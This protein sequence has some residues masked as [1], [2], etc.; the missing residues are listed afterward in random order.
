[1]SVAAYTFRGWAGSSVIELTGTSGMPAPDGTQVGG[2]DVTLVVF[3]TCSPAAT[4]EPPNVTHARLGSVGWKM[5]RDTARRL[6][7]SAGFGSGI[8]TAVTSVITAEPSVTPNTRPL[9]VPAMRM[10][11]FVGAIAIVAMA[12]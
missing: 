1:M 9:R 6:L 12:W 5:A 2:K 7:T 10:L 11:S 4:P 8:A 3:Q